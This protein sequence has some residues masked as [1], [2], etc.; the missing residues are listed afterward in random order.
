MNRREGNA[1]QQLQHPSTSPNACLCNR[2]RLSTIQGFL[3]FRWNIQLQKSQIYE[4]NNYHY[5]YATQNTRLYAVITH[6]IDNN[7]KHSSSWLK[8]TTSIWDRCCWA[9]CSHSLGGALRQLPISSMPNGLKYLWTC[10]EMTL[11]IIS[12]MVPF[13]YSVS[14]LWHVTPW[15]WQRSHF[16]VP[17]PTE[18]GIYMF[19]AMAWELS[20]DYGLDEK[21][22]KGIL[23]KVLP[24]SR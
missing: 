21:S 10:S 7:T 1:V 5:S 24:I 18:K 12:G 13:Q 14:D 22:E 6:S 19:L 8:D 16:Y 3:Y 17:E 20:W 23:Y 15:V 9:C 2:H 11:L 4:S